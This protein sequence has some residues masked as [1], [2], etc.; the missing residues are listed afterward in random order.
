MNAGFLVAIN[1]QPRHL[2]PPPGTPQPASCKL[3][4][5]SIIIKHQG[6]QIT[7]PHQKASKSREFIKDGGKFISYQFVQFPGWGGTLVVNW[8]NNGISSFSLGKS[9]T[10][11]GSPVFS[12]QRAVTLPEFYQKLVGSWVS[13]HLKKICLSNC[14]ISP[15]ENKQYLEL[16]A[17]KASKIMNHESSI[18]INHHQSSKLFKE[19]SKNHQKSSIIMSRGLQAFYC[20]YP[21]LTPSTPH[22]SQHG[23]LLHELLAIGTQH[24][25]LSGTSFI[26]SWWSSARNS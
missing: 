16:P 5:A 19:S 18:V 1:N 21:F 15:G 3:T 22:L 17:R 24:G 25:S 11:S 26:D 2:G 7:N 4:H 14:I 10:H 9:S 12:S 6:Q 8:N 20:V 23:E 13:T